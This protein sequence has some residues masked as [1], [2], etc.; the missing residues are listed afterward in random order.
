MNVD[1]WVVLDPQCSRGMHGVH[2]GHFAW[3]HDLYVYRSAA[4]TFT[5]YE[6]T[7][8]SDCNLYMYSF[9]FG[10]AGAQVGRAGRPSDSLNEL[11][12]HP[13]IHQDHIP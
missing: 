3:S 11:H 6:N 1:A 10:A 8:S 2:P 12:I 13:C 5:V 9:A 7:F 4:V